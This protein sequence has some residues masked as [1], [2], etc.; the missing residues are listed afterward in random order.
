MWGRGRK[1]EK[2]KKG[3]EKGVFL[4]RTEHPLSPREGEGRI[5]IKESRPGVRVR[6]RNII[7]T[8]QRTENLDLKG[9]KP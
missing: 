8:S 7:R 4:I 6:G 3:K 2:K 5:R 9:E 1:K